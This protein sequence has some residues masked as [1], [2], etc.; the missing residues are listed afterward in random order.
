MND[1]PGYREALEE[2]ESIVDE[3][4][5][6]TVDVDVLAEKVKRAAYL[7]RFCKERLKKTDDEVRKVLKE[8]E[9][10]DEGR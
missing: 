8:F 2:I 6:E 5:N 7:I 1:A 9:K 10:E 4:E 3:I